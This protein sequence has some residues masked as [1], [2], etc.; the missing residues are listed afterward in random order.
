MD[1]EDHSGAQEESPREQIE[2][3][4]QQIL[5]GMAGI[6]K[7]NIVKAKMVIIGMRTKIYRLEKLVER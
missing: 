6:T 7:D 1:M 3:L 4:L 5:G 2:Q